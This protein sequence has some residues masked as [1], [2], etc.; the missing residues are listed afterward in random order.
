[1]FDVTFVIIIITSFGVT[2]TIEYTAAVP[3]F[4]NCFFTMLHIRRLYIVL[5]SVWSLCYSLHIVTKFAYFICER[6]E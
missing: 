3:C 2:V 4:V 5:L 6:I 1:M